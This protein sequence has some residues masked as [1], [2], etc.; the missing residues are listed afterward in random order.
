MSALRELAQAIRLLAVAI[1]ELSLA[2]E[3]AAFWPRSY[4]ATRKLIRDEVTKSELAR[5]IVRKGGGR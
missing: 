3:K 1:R 5:H 2:L 4:E